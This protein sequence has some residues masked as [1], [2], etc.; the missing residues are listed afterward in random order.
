M[1]T[2]IAGGMVQEMKEVT[3]KIIEK[4]IRVR[5]TIITLKTCDYRVETQQ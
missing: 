3:F 2:F 4:V 5:D 1:F